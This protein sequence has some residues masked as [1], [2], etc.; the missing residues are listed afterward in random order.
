LPADKKNHLQGLE[1]RKILRRLNVCDNSTL[2]GFPLHDGRAP[3][4]MS[5]GGER[6]EPA[7]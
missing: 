3:M 2:L 5:K 4:M 1:D 6:R 7:F